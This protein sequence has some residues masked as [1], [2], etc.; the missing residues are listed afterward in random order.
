MAE[1][2]KAERQVIGRGYEP[3][4]VPLDQLPK[5]KDP[6]PGPGAPLKKTATTEDEDH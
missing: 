6:G 1:R 2:K 4:H 3:G 5:P